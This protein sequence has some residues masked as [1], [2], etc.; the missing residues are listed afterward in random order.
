MSYDVL[1]KN[2][3][4]VDGSGFSRSRAVG[5]GRGGNILPLVG[6]NPISLSAMGAAAWERTATPDE[7]AHMQ[8]LLRESLDAGAWGWS[9]T[10]SPTHAGPKGQ[11]VPTRLAN[12]EER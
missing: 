7:I 3:M 10:V 12:N 4:L 1:V 6:L 9:T 5:T 2:G 11:P 8:R